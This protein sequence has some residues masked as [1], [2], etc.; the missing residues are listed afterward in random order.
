MKKIKTIKTKAK[1]NFWPK[2]SQKKPFFCLAP[3]AD[4]TDV[5][6]RAMFVKYG[7][8]DVLWT[9]FVSADGLCSVGKKKLLHILKYNEK[10]R[11]IVAQIFGAKPE[12]IKTAC[13]II[14]QLGFDGVDI[15]MGCPDKSV[16]RQGAGSALIKTPKL[17]REIIRSAIAGVNSTGHKIPVSVKTRI[18]FNKKTELEDWITEII[19]ENISALTIHARTKKEMSEVPADWTQIKKVVELVKKSGRNIPVIGNGDIKS[20]AEGRIKAKE[21]GCAG[22]MIGRGAFGQPWIFAGLEKTKE[23]KLRILLEHTK[24]FDKLLGK[25]RNFALMRKHYKAY[26]N[27]FSGAKELRVELMKTNSYLEV[28]KLISDYLSKKA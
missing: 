10:E 7:K 16:V 17:A 28:K 6:F 4:V 9:E 24:T 18:G 8:P 19:Q 25:E 1:A 14:A 20:L 23:Q 3:M 21:T 11:P 2:V 13:Q 5:A 27:G 15:N 12:N 26:V 22:I